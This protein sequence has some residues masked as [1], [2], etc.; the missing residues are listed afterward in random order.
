M[1][2]L[3]QIGSDQYFLLSQRVTQLPTSGWI[4]LLRKSYLACAS[5]SV[6]ATNRYTRHDLHIICRDHIFLNVVLH[7]DKTLERFSELLLSP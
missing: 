3:T 1:V 5:C 4:R 7:H 6:L 2:H